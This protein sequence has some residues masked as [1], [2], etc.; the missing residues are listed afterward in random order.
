MSASRLCRY[1]TSLL[2]CFLLFPF[3]TVSDTPPK[4]ELQTISSSNAQQLQEIFTIEM[5]TTQFTRN[6]REIIFSLDGEFLS[7][8]EFNSS[9]LELWNL[10]E[11]I[12]VGLIETPNNQ[13]I[14]KSEFADSN[15]LIVASETRIHLWDITTGIVVATIDRGES[16]IPAIPFDLHESWMAYIEATQS[17]YNDTV[18]LYDLETLSSF[19]HLR[20][21]SV[22]EVRFSADG[23]YL[24]STAF[25]GSVKLWDL[26]TNNDSYQFTLIREANNV[27]TSFPTFSSDSHLLTYQIRTEPFK[28]LQI[29][30]LDENTPQ[31]PTYESG[32]PISGYS[33]IVSSL[34]GDGLSIQLWNLT[35]GQNL[36]YLDGF[37]PSGVIA[38][39]SFDETVI[40]TIEVEGIQLREV[41]T[42]KILYSISDNDARY[43]TLSPD[44]KLLATWGFSNTLHFW[45]ILNNSH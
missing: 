10:N 30:S 35:N 20:H 38:G 22:N 42:G 12:R 16:E 37:F 3:Y 32:A 7:V 40:L 23:K 28:E 2:L 33:D 4:L 44:G 21:A 25:D 27:A 14:T 11:M 19:G 39:I 1:C 31:S 29:V 41:G 26:A 15:L 8:R 34:S 6:Q 18:N 13:T 9:S 24:A 36:A 45:G 5:G 17:D 43:T